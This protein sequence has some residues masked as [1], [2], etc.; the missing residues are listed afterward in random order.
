[1]IARGV[2]YGL[3]G[4]VV[5]A[6][7]GCSMLR[8]GAE[9][10]YRVTIEVV[11][12]EETLAASR[13][14]S[15]KISRPDVALASRYQGQ[16]RGEAVALDLPSGQTLFAILRGAEGGESMGGLLPERWLGD[17]GRAARGDQTRFSPDRLADVRDIASRVGETIKLDCAARPDWCP[18][19]ITFDDSS[20]PMSVRQIAHEDIP[21][22]FG[23][24]YFLKSITIE[25]T[26]DDVDFD[27]ERRLSWLS[28]YPEPRLDRAYRG[29]TNPSI[30][31]L[32]THGD[33]RRGHY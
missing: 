33:F 10:R 32:L 12:D 26:N 25:I 2:F 27:I 13:V 19:L 21:E 17:I 28:E 24:E 4:S 29:S 16:F 11:S 5:L 14:W 1:M 6:A 15:W 20:N 31:Q 23:S 22:V 30:A 18:M 9:V 3:L 8:G 7:G